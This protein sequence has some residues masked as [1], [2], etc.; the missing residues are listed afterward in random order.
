MVTITGVSGSGKSTL[1]TEVLLTA[2]YQHFKKKTNGKKVYQAVNGFDNLNDIVSIDQKPI[3]KSTRSNPISY[4]GAFN[5]IRS[6]FAKTISAVKA[7][8]KAGAFSFNNTV[9]R[10]PTCAGTGFEHV[11]MQF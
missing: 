1:L 2:G 6:I 5:E 8:L 9:G 3:G 10:C 11:E 4:I 7:D